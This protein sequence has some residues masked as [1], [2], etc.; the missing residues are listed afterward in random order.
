M[1]NKRH[2]NAMKITIVGPAHPYRG[3]IAKFNDVLAENLLKEGYDVDIVNFSLQYPS[4]LFPGST[5][6]TDAP[7]TGTVKNVRQLNSVNPFNWC[8]VGRRIVKHAPDLVIFRYWMP[9]MAPAL[10][11]IA[12]K[13]KR[14]GI[15]TVALADNI[16][17]HEG[18]FYDKPCTHYFL[19]AMDKVV[20]MSHQVGAELE[21]FNYKGA[22]A[23]APHPIYDTYG[24]CVTRS[25]A[26][27]VL[28][29]DDKYRYVMFFGFIREYKGLDLLLQAW[30]EL[31]NNEDKRLLIAGEFYS[32]REQYMGLIADLGLEDQIVLRDSYIPEDQVLYYFSAA[33]LVVQPY[34]T[35]TQSGITQVAY[36]FG[37]PMVVTNV[38][39]LSEIV[40]DGVVG[41][42]VEVNPKAIAA[43]IEDF[44]VNG[45]EDQ[46]RANI[47]HEKERFSWKNMIGVIVE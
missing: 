33:D 20:Y 38:G 45:R 26:C 32:N 25:E 23:F 13:L 16:V 5:Q 36:N 39:G 21:Q 7:T 34:R 14:A 24:D 41:Y 4:F 3:G 8:G 30:K 12:R 31:P 19:K 43:A 11:T 9:F 28:N 46:F 1:R 18:H 37:V 6:Y 29:L 15:R 27:A 2:L 40:P 42:V 10:G 47:L 44:Y 22:K 35:A 17:P